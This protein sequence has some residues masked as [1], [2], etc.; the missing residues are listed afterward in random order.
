M[1]GAFSSLGSDAP[2]VALKQLA[3]LARRQAMT[4]AIA[5]IFYLL[6]IVFLM[7]VLMLPIVEKPKPM[8]SSGSGH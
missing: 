6:T 8:G 5:D 2:L 1:T 3:G 7:I 4:M